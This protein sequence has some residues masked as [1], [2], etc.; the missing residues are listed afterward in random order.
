M[1][2]N[3][4]NIFTTKF[5]VSRFIA[6]ISVFIIIII[7][8]RLHSVAKDPAL[9]GIAVGNCELTD[10]PVA[11]GEHSGNHFKIILRNVRAGHVI[12]DDV[13]SINYQSIEGIVEPSHM[14]LDDVT[15]LDHQRTERISEH[16]HMTSANTIEETN[17]MTSS[18]VTIEAAGHMTCDDVTMTIPQAIEE[19]REAGF[20]NYFG[21]QR[22]GTVNVGSAPIGSLVGLAMLKNDFVSDFQVKQRDREI[23]KI[24]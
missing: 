1:F 9:S 22:F 5:N 23:V 13:T 4:R 2:H 20:I 7:I 21:P 14:T 16:G 18:N 15:A 8:G 24:L 3:T 12:S 17:H 19:I 10:H 6:P 11:I